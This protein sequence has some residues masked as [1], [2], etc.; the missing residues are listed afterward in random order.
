MANFLRQDAIFA[1]VGS[2]DLSDYATGTWTPVDASGAGLTF[3]SVSAAYTKIGNMVFAYGRLTYP[4]TVSGVP[5][6][7]GGLP[8]TVANNLYASVA[9][10]SFMAGV[11]GGVWFTVINSTHFQAISSSGGSLS[12]GNLSTLFVSFNLVY[13]VT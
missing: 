7:I 12:N 10:A 5:A 6:V 1:A 2:G 4:T 8:F 9:N 11:A 3:T 13:P